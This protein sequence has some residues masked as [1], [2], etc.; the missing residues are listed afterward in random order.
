[1]PKSGFKYLSIPQAIKILSF[2]DCSWRR[3]VESNRLLFIISYL[4]VFK[5]YGCFAWK[6]TGA[7]L[8]CTRV[9]VY[10]R[11]QTHTHTAMRYRE[12]GH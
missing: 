5:I 9:F 3:H 4:M 6:L 1:M 11:T 12:I 7:S 8:Y 10:E 2:G